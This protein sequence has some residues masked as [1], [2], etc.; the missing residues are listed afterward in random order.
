MSTWVLLRGLT[1]EARHWGG[2]SALLESRIP[3]GDA[4]LALD[5]PGNGTQ[6]REASPWSV[7]AMMASAR[8][9]LAARALPPPYVLVSLSLGGM[10]ALEWAAVAPGELEACVLVNSSVRGLSPFW[11]RLQPACYGTLLRSLLA[12]TAAAR[13]RAVY[14]MTSTRAPDAA[15]IAAWVAYAES[16][17]VSAGN[18]LR[19]LVAAA[20]FRAPARLQ[21]PA[22]VLA[23][24]G[25]RLVSPACSRAMALAWG[26]DLREHPSAGHDLPLDD[27]QWIVEQVAR[28]WP[29]HFLRG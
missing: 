15:L 12:G 7:A 8:E 14:A 27:P 29:A 18:A 10:V 3:V 26:A 19:Q 16:R 24:R 4:V 9:Q 6:W 23:S 2:F 21:V 22:L 17:P 28:W 1:R 11:Q 25:D 20:R 13:E 5:L